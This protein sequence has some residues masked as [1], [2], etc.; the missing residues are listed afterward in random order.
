MPHD[1]YTQ[2]WSMLKA[3]TVER[4]KAFHL[5]AMATIGID[6]RPKLRTVVLRH[7]DE[8]A[9]IIRFHTDARSQK[10]AELAA[11]PHI[12]AHFYDQAQNIQ[13]RLSGV[14]RIEATDTQA[15]AKA[16]AEAR[17]MSKVCYRL[18]AGPGSVLETGD[19][20]GYLPFDA[21]GDDPGELNFRT[22]TIAVEAMDI[23][24][25]KLN[26]NRRAVFELSGS[27][28]RGRWVVP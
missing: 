3:A 22:V 13:V 15:A 21:A 4:R 18:D 27:K 20:Y 14:A 1:L 6:G 26:A 19:G 28:V 16:W 9:Q 25:L 12:E 23:V 10:I 7:V 17:S 2:A 11:N 24:L 8:G 5:G